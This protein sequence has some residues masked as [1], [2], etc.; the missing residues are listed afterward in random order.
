MR[1]T[2]R[3]GGS[4]VST[5]DWV[6]YVVG[7]LAA[8]GVMLI[9]TLMFVGMGAAAQRPGPA[10][11]TVFQIMMWS[12]AGALAAGLAILVATR[13]RGRGWPFLLLVLPPVI[14]FIAAQRY[15]G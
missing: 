14:S 15:F 7:W 13:G 1:R 10:I 12:F 8:A 5:L 4:A 9:A 3:S 11:N 2:P 6:M